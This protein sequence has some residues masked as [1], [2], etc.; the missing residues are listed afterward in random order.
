MPTSL[1]RRL[2]LA[3]RGL[4]YVTAVSLVLLALVAGVVSQLLFKPL[5]LLGGL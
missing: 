5:L 4:W 2:R 1:R 3:R